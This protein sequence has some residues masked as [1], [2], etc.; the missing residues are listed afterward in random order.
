MRWI[1]HTFLACSMLIG[2]AAWADDATVSPADHASIV[3]IIRQQMEAFRR[4]D[5][6]GAFGFASPGIQGMFDHDPA[7]FMAMVRQGYP[8]VYRPRT[9]SFGPTETVDGQIIQKVDIEGPD[10][11]LRTAIY[12]MEREADG[13]WRIAGCMLTE[14]A[15]AGA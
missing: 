6:P 10:G 15:D 11:V 13:S 9:T 5:G 4:D 7:R 14:A 8:P 1:G 2:V 3:N 12:T